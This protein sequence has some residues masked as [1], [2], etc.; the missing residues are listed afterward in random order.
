M[1]KKIIAL[2]VV[3][4]YILPIVASDCC[5]NNVVTPK[6][7]TRSQ[8]LN[9][10]RRIV[11]FSDEFYRP[12][13]T[14]FYD[15]LYFAA[16]YSRSFRSD[17][18]ASCLFGDA[19]SDCKLKI[20]GSRVDNRDSNALLAD[21]FY[22]P[23]DFESEVTIDPVIQNFLVDMCYHLGLDNWLKG[24]YFY[25]QAPITWTKWDL[26]FCEQHITEGTNGYDA[27]YFTPA[28]LN[29]THLLNSFS[30][31]ALGDAPANNIF[32]QDITATTTT[33]ETIT[34]IFNPLKCAKMGN[35]GNKTKTT[36]SEV[37][38]ALG[39]NA[40][41]G[42]HYHAGLNVQ[43][44]IPTGNK[45]KPAFLFAP[46]NGNDG[47]WELG[48]GGNAQLKLYL[49]EDEN[50][51]LDFYMGADITH[52]FKN[53]QSRTFDL[54][55][56]PLSRY[57]LAAKMTAPVNKGLDNVFNVA[58]ILQ[59]DHEFTP[60]ANLTTIDV[61]VSIG[62]Q[63]DLVLMFNYTWNQW[64]FDLG[65]NLWAR[66]CESIHPRKG[67]P[68]AL[69]RNAWVLKGDAQVYGF[70]RTTDIL[71]E[72]AA[73]ELS[74]SESDATIYA[75][76]NYLASGASTPGLVTAGRLNPHIDHANQAF[77]GNNQVLD[78]VVG[79]N[80]QINTS[81]DPIII[82]N[83]DLNLV[84][85][86]GFSNKIFT[87]LSYE[88]AERK[89]W[90]ETFAPIFGV[91]FEVEFAKN[92][93]CQDANDSCPTYCNGPCVRCAASQWGIWIK[94]GLAFR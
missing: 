82:T 3:A 49:S 68:T 83:M 26:N 21:Y 31:Y 72:G 67:C 9:Q 14:D 56:K 52:M 81:I 54:Q 7:V 13:Q 1:N 27:G 42:N 65:Y 15:N 77:A 19:L 44:S 38:A 69:D 78:A 4:F 66:S 33:S 85:T 57:M 75:G 2:S 71:L 34:T 45:V 87:Y 20:Q 76:I 6:F 73:V 30:A 51:S 92:D 25:I 8:G 60:V 48:I 12:F 89:K 94:G 22:L 47:H 61:D 17:D 16:E 93:T 35:C 90:G 79:T 46:Q 88:G 70:A 10:P 5:T 86:Q 39:W 84:R 53:H 24:L 11:G 50:R 43:V 37:R 62:V 58:P 59:F 18:I 74:A 28:A 91:G 23:T 63:V 55:D 64:S 80:G 41:L 29:R 40:L 36:L 32:T